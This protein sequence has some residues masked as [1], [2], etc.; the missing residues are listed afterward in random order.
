M[1]GATVHALDLSL[2]A[3][4]P[5]HT[6]ELFSNPIAPPDHEGGLAAAAAAAAHD[7]RAMANLTNDDFRKLLMTP[8]PAAASSS[9]SSSLSASASNPAP[10]PYTQ[11]KCV[12]MPHA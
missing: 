4:S 9:S 7:K 8:R 2:L 5:V 1:K 6:Q 11:E 10:L 3:P 12:H